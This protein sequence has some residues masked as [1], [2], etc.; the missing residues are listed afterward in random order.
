MKHTLLSSQ[1]AARYLGIKEGTLRKWKWSKSVILPYSKVG[2]L[3]KYKLSDLNE[4]INRT[5]KP[6]DPRS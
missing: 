5:S 1:E 3:V 2:R 4:Y 6:Q